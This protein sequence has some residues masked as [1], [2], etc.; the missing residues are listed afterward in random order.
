EGTGHIY[1]VEIETRV[2]QQLTEGTSE[3]ILPIW[4][5][6]GRFIYFSSNRTGRHEIWRVPFGGGDATQ[7]TRFGGFA[8][9]ES[10][11]GQVIYYT[12]NPSQAGLWR[13]PFD[14]GEESLA[15][16]ALRPVFWGSWTVVD[17]G[18]LFLDTPPDGPPPC[19]VKLFD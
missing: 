17:S 16:A 2:V 8:S 10:T 13:V 18:I 19:S 14:G 9:M 4:S 7:V 12:R 5:H 3:N 1:V 6:D 15:L 11:N